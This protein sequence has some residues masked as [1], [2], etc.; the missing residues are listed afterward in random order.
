MNTLQLTDKQLNLIQQ[1]L[2]FY[3][4]V[5]IGQFKAIKDHPTFEKFLYSVCTPNKE[6][7]VGDRTPQ[8]E[9]LEIKDG[10]ALISGSIKD[11][12]WSEEHEWKDL[13][14][15]KLSTDYSKYHQ[16]RSDIDKALLIPRNMLIND[17]SMSINGS[18]G[19]YNK[20][21]SDDC[22][23]AFDIFQVIRYEKWKND[24]D[25]SF[26]TVDSSIHFSHKKDDSSNKIK[27]ILNDD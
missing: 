24:E 2:D 17:N 21:V 25:R 20:N 5:G 8:G 4:R 15:V 19:I 11:N 9:V 7:E 26:M 27:C 22:R 10:K 13:K 14:D 6:I 18:W 1:A 12:R 23:I 3:I 16:L